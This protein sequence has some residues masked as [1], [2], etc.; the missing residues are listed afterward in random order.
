[1][2]D[3][4][5]PNA[6]SE[7]PGSPFPDTDAPVKKGGADALPFWSF[8][9]IPIGTVVALFVLAGVIFV[10]I[11]RCHGNGRRTRSADTSQLQ[12]RQPHSS[13]DEAVALENP[14]SVKSPLRQVGCTVDALP[15]EAALSSP[16]EISHPTK[17]LFV[18]AAYEPRPHGHFPCSQQN[19]E[20]VSPTSYDVS[21]NSGS[22]TKIST[23][24]RSA[25]S[26][27][28][29]TPNYTADFATDGPSND[30]PELAAADATVSPNA[31]SGARG[32]APW[33]EEVAC[34][35]GND[36]SGED[37]NHN[38]SAACEPCEA[39]V[40]PGSPDSSYQVKHMET[41]DDGID[42]F[43]RPK[44]RQQF[45][46]A[47]LNITAF[48][49]GSHRRIEWKLVLSA[50]RGL[51]YADPLD[52]CEPGAL[53]LHNGDI[54]TFEVVSCTFP[55]PRMLNAARMDAISRLH[56]KDTRAG[57]S[58]HTVTTV[59]LPQWWDLPDYAQ[60]ICWMIADTN[61]FYARQTSRSKIL[62]WHHVRCGYED[63]LR[64][65]LLAEHTTLFRVFQHIDTSAVAS[66]K[67]FQKVAAVKITTEGPFSSAA[68]LAFLFYSDA[69][70]PP[71]HFSKTQYVDFLSA[72]GSQRKFP[73][74]APGCAL[75]ALG[76][77]TTHGTRLYYT[78]SPCVTDKY[79]TLAEGQLVFLE[80]L[81]PLAIEKPEK[82][83]YVAI[84]GITEVVPLPSTT[85]KATPM[86]LCRWY[87]CLIV[88]RCT[89]K[90]IEMRFVYWLVRDEFLDFCSTIHKMEQEDNELIGAPNSGG[91]S[92]SA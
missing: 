32:E 87:A 11:R 57:N 20:S 58:A 12:S 4:D 77:I 26:K 50:L 27:T 90:C 15:T 59:T 21:R 68:K 54:E 61:F 73:F 39:D 63:V 13:D 28:S 40:P 79:A 2:S 18:C 62:P 85:L 35:V 66:Y 14:L 37:A 36:D 48:M 75:M 76:S 1:M 80:A 60:Y 34:F 82:G 81:T 71:L 3:S 47:V 38:E 24:W 88:K 64:Q 72:E 74:T 78:V 83:L 55:L 22:P 84:D 44:Y 69:V 6:S 65:K 23:A 92:H 9:A 7:G 31:E 45:P 46:S 41:E 52:N 30:E 33:A 8:I 43:D 16:D 29:D 25:L 56:H 67:C 17:E 10:C 91:D 49:S 5:S 42:V 53:L 19:G 89:E 86:V 70:I 51:M